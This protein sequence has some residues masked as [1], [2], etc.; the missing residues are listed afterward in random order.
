MLIRDQT[1]GSVEASVGGERRI[2]HCDLVAVDLLRSRESITLG[3]A[4]AP[5][6]TMGCIE[7]AQG[8]IAVSRHVDPWDARD[9]GMPNECDFLQRWKKFER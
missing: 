3:S 2:D 5:Q 8:G 6:C 1:I 4:V 7:P 9:K